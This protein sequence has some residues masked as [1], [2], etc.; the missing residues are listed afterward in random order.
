MDNQKAFTEYFRS[1]VTAQADTEIDFKSDKFYIIGSNELQYGKIDS[2]ICSKIFM[3]AKKN[4]FANNKE[5]EK[6]FQIS[7]IICAKTIKT[8]YKANEKAKNDI[9][10]LTGV[11]Y[12]P[13]H[14]K[15]DGSLLFDSAEK[16]IPWF[17]REY[18][19]PMVEP[20]LAV[21]IVDS[22]DDFI[23][24][25][26]D[27]VE[28]IKNWTDYYHYFSEF[29][30]N[31][32]HSPFNED[33]I[34]NMDKQEPIFRLE[35]SSYIF[36]DKKINST[37]QII[38]LYNELLIDE[39]PKPLYS[40][41]I[42]TK[43]RASE[44][45]LENSISNMQSHCG[46][47]GGEYPLSPSQ[48]EAVNHYKWMQEGDILAVNGPP[49]TG[50]TTLLQSIVADM[51]VK[52]AINQDKA[53]L[54][55]A[56]STNNQAVTN[57]ISSFGSIKRI[58]ISNLET[59]W[60]E[61]VDSFA[62]Y[63]PSVGKIREAKSKGYQYTNQKGEYFVSDIEAKENMQASLEKLINN[64]SRYF[65]DELED[66]NTCMK[67]LHKELL[68]LEARKNSLLSIVKELQNYHFEN[69]DFDVVIPELNRQIDKKQVA[70]SQMQQRQ[71]E[72]EKEY[73]S[74]PV[75]IRL[76]KFFK[77]FSRKIQTAFRSFINEDEQEFL[78]EYMSLDEIKE[79]YSFRHSDFIKK[80]A[81][82]KKHLE[83]LVKYKK[84]Y[85]NEYTLLDQ[86]N[87]QFFYTDKETGLAKK[88][89]LNLNDINDL[90]DTKI[91]Y[92][93][94]WLA[95]HYYEC[96]WVN[97]EDSLSEKQ[98]GLNYDN[99]VK[100]YYRRLSMITPCM[101]MTFYMLPKQF[102]VYGDN[103]GKKYY[104]YNYID[105]LIVDEA[106]QVSPEIAAC[107]FSLAKKSVV[108][109]DTHQIEPV[110][111]V[112]R[113][114]DKSLALSSGV[115][116]SL[117]GFDILKQTGLNSS[118][119]NV[120]KVACKSCKYE[121]FSE[122]GLFLSE[123]R[124][125]YDE[126]IQYCNQLVYNGKLDPKRGKGKDDS[127]LAIKLWPQMGYKQINTE[128][129]TKNGGS[130]QNYLEAE[131]IAEWLKNNL[132]LIVES[133]PKEDLSNL[134]GIITPFK[135]QVQC[136]STQLKKYLPKQHSKISV[137]TVHTFQGA[138]RKIIIMSTVY[139]SQ[140]SC[141]FINVNTSIMNVAVSRAKDCFF[142]F[143]DIN[144]LKGSKSSELLK[145]CISQNEIQ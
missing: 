10:E 120:M 26:V 85:D 106:G 1:N 111:G 42:S 140:E 99:I 48:R 136:I 15:F 62:V 3:E 123:H 94:F 57:I 90:I 55:V 61:G 2:S 97:G 116:S 119:S 127:D 130:R 49:G 46:Q 18:L 118:M 78:N 128:Y 138:E 144:C 84:L 8:I 66:I 114:L 86:H 64:C 142:V 117:D 17:P 134:V 113:A 72:W 21:G 16:K 40:N 38:N 56:S 102:Q 101:V 69:N 76:L 103:I 58:G 98:K 87:V 7:V 71:S 20:N 36:I 25:H 31:V 100:Q 34:N 39:S 60:I 115:I 51:Y 73:Y 22:V 75:Y 125:C 141:Y 88:Y 93:E 29:Y 65:G 89:L 96:R 45:L 92:M 145:R 77:P 112:N 107:S 52:K 133:Y 41:F 68:F 132:K 109:G 122:K 12:I 19:Q 14:L 82:L 30:E 53:P 27:Q 24:S 105:L 13:A 9:E 70:I 121:K 44:P 135:A 54:I 139:G 23:S 5:K 110:W 11:Y 81:D 47:M 104:L 63:F 131:T 80:L 79:K 35:K 74:I 95:V 129:S 83:T 4:N 6:L 37:R 108:V 28:L 124:R 137:G 33:F 32:T 43:E 91:R 126:I 50:K 143:G 67:R 59:R